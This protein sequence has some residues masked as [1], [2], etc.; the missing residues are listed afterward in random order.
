M[1]L[2][3]G[4]GYDVHRR[5]PGRAL[6]L[7][8]V[9]FD[10]PWGLEG[11]SDAD[12]VCHAVGDA[13]LGALALGDLGT[14][15]PPS[16]PRWKNASSLDLLRRIRLLAE[17]AGASVV[18]VDVTLLAEEPR[19]SPHYPAMRAQLADAL[20]VPSGRVSVKATTPEGMGAMGR[21]EGLAAWAVALVEAP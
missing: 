3:V 12:V 10:L 14:H 13:V 19:V 21:G 11:H 6:V 7:G 20:G 16:D 9:S 18:N 8:G 15:F 1:G 17:G 5:V 4:M 2:R